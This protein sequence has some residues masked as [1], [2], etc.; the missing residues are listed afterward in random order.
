MLAATAIR[1]GRTA[2]EFAT[3]CL[4][5]VVCLPTGKADSGVP[6]P[7]A[8]LALGRWL[9]LCKL[10]AANILGW[11]TPLGRVEGKSTFHRWQALESSATREAVLNC[12]AGRR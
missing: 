12:F 6:C 1:R 11:A 2:G 10:A 9:P 8:A 4:L 3:R 5:S 7:A